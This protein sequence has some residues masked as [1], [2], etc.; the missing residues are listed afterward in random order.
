[1][2]RRYPRRSKRS[3]RSRRKVSW[4]NKK[5]SGGQLASMTARKALSLAKYMYGLINVEKKKFDVS[6]N[7]GPTTAGA[8]IPLS[9]VAQGDTDQDRNG[10]SVLAKYLYARGTV[11]FD[12]D[13]PYSRC[14]I[15]L[16]QDK[17]QQSDTTPSV[18]DVLDPTF[19]SLI[20]APL[21]NLTV[22]RFTVLRDFVITSNNVG[23][24]EA[25]ARTRTWG[26]NVKMTQHLRWNGPLGTDVQKNHLYLLLVSDQL[27]EFPTVTYNT[28]LTY[29]DN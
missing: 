13:V 1:M 7:A 10:L 3:R 19:A 11:I 14:R 20:D 5:Y 15:M 25:I 18:N 23:S 2:P 17:Q 29:V 4:W 27:V 24:T 12:K 28:R 6:S 9:H 8:M 22:G 16:I 21:N 26:F